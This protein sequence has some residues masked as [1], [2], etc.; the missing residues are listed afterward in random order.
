ME[1]LFI[2]KSIHK[3]LTYLKNISSATYIPYNKDAI[4]MIRK[5][6]GSLIGYKYYCKKDAIK[7][8]ERIPKDSL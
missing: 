1:R 5:T 3:T 4:I 8:F 7:Q 6:N 2:N